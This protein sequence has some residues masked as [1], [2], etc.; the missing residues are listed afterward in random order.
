MA[1]TGLFD[2]FG[3]PTWPGP[4]AGESVSK[5]D[6]PGDNLALRALDRIA[7]AM[8]DVEKWRKEARECDRFA[9]GKHFSKRDYEALTLAKRPTAAFNS[10]QKW[11]RFISGVEQQAKL[12]INFLPRNPHNEAQI[13]GGELATKAYQ[14]AVSSSSGDNERSRAFLDMVRR[15]LGWTE[16]GLD[17]ARDVRGLPFLKRVDGMEMVW[18]TSARQEC[19]ADMRW[20]ARIREVDKREAIIRFPDAKPIIAAS[21]GLSSDG[22][23]PG[24]STLISEK[25]AVPVE[26]AQWPMTKPGK[27]KVVEYQ[28]YEEVA[29]VYFYDHLEDKEEWLDEHAFERYRKRYKAIAPRLRMRAADPTVGMTPQE[30]AKFAALPDDVDHDRVIMRE[31][32]RCIIIGQHVVWGPHPLPGRRFTFNALTGQWDDEDEVWYGFFRY[33]IDPQRY[34]TKFANRMMEALVRGSNGGLVAEED[35][36]LNPTTVEDKFSQIGSVIYT[37]TGKF[38]KWKEKPQAQMPE[39]AS[40][41]FGVC[42]RLMNEVTG[43]TPEASMGAGAGDTPA[44]T[45]RQRQLA[46][47][48]L[49]AAEF[50]TLRR[51]Q[52]E[53]ARTLFDILQLVADDRWVRIGDGVDSQAIQLVRDPFYLEYDVVFDEGTRDPNVREQYWASI[54]RLA[55][56]LLRV[57]KFTPSMIDFAPWPASVRRDIKQQMMKEAAQQQKMAQ[58]GISMGGRGKPSSIQ[59]NQA[60]VRA[61]QAKGTLDEAKAIQL[62][63]GV[64]TSKAKLLLDA[65]I[66][67]DQALQ[68]GME[69]Q[70]SGARADRE[71]NQK[72]LAVG[73][74]VMHTLFGG[75]SGGRNA[76]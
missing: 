61:L 41:M 25:H 47:M 1:T 13:S 12:E 74:D 23:K 27:V 59:E 53:E 3:P 72:G 44:L 52:G 35:T 22:D 67:G 6:A 10:A 2:T 70:A 50:N 20:V 43:I 15:G 63:E 17:R 58:M 51:Y 48:I 28:W 8:P 29:G 40:E 34:L 68:S 45:M 42:M 49:L 33:L 66:R 56:T 11:L 38:D 7:G 21:T 46:S 76:E 36:F 73:A 54:E 30:Q 14:W 55:P 69:A 24:Q 39:G 65:I 16:A 4:Q 31:Y 57:N 37:K 75:G 62:T 9:A 26:H 60:R 71:V 19:L 18:D 64:N 5:P 32:K